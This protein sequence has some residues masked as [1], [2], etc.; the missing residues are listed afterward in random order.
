MLYANSTI[1]FKMEKIREHIKIQKYR[2]STPEGTYIK[3]ASIFEKKS[4]MPKNPIQR[5]NA[6]NRRK[7]STQKRNIKSN[8]LENAQGTCNTIK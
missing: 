2:Y 5:H 6:K 4:K 1:Y 7:S 8:I 3:W